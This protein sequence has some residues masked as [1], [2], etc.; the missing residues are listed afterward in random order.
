LHPTLV[1]TLP[2][3]GPRIGA[4]VRAADPGADVVDCD[5]LESAVA[6]AFAW[7]EPRGGAVL[8]SP[9]APSFGQFTNYRARAEAFAAAVRAL[10]D[11]VS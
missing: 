9:G 3:N 8:L 1:V 4:A 11:P 5:D 2:A 6:A 7:A 10:A